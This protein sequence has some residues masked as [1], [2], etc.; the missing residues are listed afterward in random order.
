MSCWRILDIEDAMSNVGA[1]IIMTASTSANGS[2]IGNISDIGS[3]SW[4]YLL[5]IALE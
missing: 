5:E 2:G 1:T 3:I 4:R